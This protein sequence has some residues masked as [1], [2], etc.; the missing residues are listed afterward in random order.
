MQL[1]CENFGRFKSYAATNLATIFSESGR[2]FKSRKIISHALFPRVCT[3]S[4]MYQNVAS[5]SLCLWVFTMST[6]CLVTHNGLA[7]WVR[8]KF[9]CFKLLRCGDFPLAQHYLIY[10]EN[11]RVTF[12]FKPLNLVDLKVVTIKLREGG[13]KNYGGKEEKKQKNYLRSVSGK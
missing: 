4:S 9:C 8:N 11:Y 1:L 13:K 7:G 5:I 2:C 6:A 12:P 10:L 3:R